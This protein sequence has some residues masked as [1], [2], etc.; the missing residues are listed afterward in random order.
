MIGHSKLYSQP[1]FEF[2]RNLPS[3][4]TSEINFCLYQ[5]L[6]YLSQ[7]ILLLAFRSTT[8]PLNEAITNFLGKHPANTRLI[9]Y[10]QTQQLP[11]NIEALEL[12]ANPK[13]LVLAGNFNP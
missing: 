1:N 9:V 4:V 5:G 6:P 3:V 8:R 11:V 12:N 2:L 13:H 10:V 7:Q